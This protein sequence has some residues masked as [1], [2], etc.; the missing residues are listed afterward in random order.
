MKV[1]QVVSSDAKPVRRHDP[2]HPLSVISPNLAA[3]YFVDNASGALPTEYDGVSAKLKFVAPIQPGANTI[4]IGIAD[5]GDAIL[6]SGMFVS[7]TSPKRQ[8]VNALRLIHS[9]ALFE[10]ALFDNQGDQ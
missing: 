1:E 9:L 4:T 5:T 3:G 6:D 10:V 7:L 8:R 2:N